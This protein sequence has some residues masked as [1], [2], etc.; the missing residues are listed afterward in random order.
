MSTIP[1]VSG[2]THIGRGLR[3]TVEIAN[4]GHEI[5]NIAEATSALTKDLQ[6]LSGDVQCC[7]RCQADLHQQMQVCCFDIDQA[8][9][10][11]RAHNVIPAWQWLVRKFRDRTSVSTVLIAKGKRFRA[12]AGTGKWSRAW[13]ALPMD[14]LTR[15]LQV[16]ITCSFVCV[17]QLVFELLGLCIGGSLG[18]A[19]V[20]VKLAYEHHFFIS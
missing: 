8:F 7:L 12:M 6:G 19:A 13:C 18:G 2:W 14:M 3:A 4:V 20:A 1:F 11:C 9:E 16:A 15:A 10:S 17:G 5:F